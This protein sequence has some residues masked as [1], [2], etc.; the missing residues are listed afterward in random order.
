MPVILWLAL[1]TAVAFAVGYALTAAKRNQ[2]R[3][4]LFPLHRS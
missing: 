1:P 4:L 2:Q 3:S